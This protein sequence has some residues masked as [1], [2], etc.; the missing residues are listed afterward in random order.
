MPLSVSPIA[1]LAGRLS[2]SGI[3]VT[4]CVL[5]MSA[6]V[7]GLMA[8]KA[9]E[10]RDT[11][12]AQSRTESLNLTHSLSEH[13]SHTLQAVDLVMTEIVV[14]LQHYTPTKERFDRH[15]RELDDALPQL[16]YVAALDAAG[17]F[18]HASGVETPPHNNADRSYFIHHRD[19]DND[20]LLIS[21]PLVSRTTGLPV[22]ILTKRMKHA[23]GSFAGVLLAT[24]DTGYFQVFY[25]S[26]QL[27]A[28]GTIGLIRTDGV[29]LMHW[30]SMESGRNLADRDLFRQHLPNN[31]VGYFK[32]IS[33]FDGTS[34]FLAYKKSTLYPIVVTVARPESDVLASTCGPT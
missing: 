21:G 10:S 6:C 2:A 27:G 26:L 7:L 30:P 17:N 9:L 25:K 20:D 34:K 18:I 28:N 5:A 32:S 15:L 24:I 33:T 4:L 8:W 31:P 13:L 11:A 16:S 29:L 22:V 1:R 23:D 19:N 3:I 12:L 14:S